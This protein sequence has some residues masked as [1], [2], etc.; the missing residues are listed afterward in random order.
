MRS[1]SAPVRSSPPASRTIPAS[2]STSAAGFADDPGERVDEP[3]PAPD[4]HG[5]P[6]EL[7]RAGDHPRH[8]P[9]RRALGPE[10]C[11]EHPGGEEAVRALR[12]ERAGRPVATRRKGVPGELERTAPTEPPQHP[13]CEAQPCARPELRA[14]DAEAEVDRGHELVELPLPRRAVAGRP[15]VELGDVRLERRVEEHRLT[16]G[17]GGRGR[18]LGV[19]V[20]EAPHVELVRELRIRRGSCEQRMPGA[21]HLVREAGDRVVGLR[22]DRAAE[23]VARLED[24]DAPA[25]S[26]EERRRGERVDPRPD[27]DGVEPGH[28]ATLRGAPE[29]ERGDAGPF[30]RAEPS[31]TRR[32]TTPRATLTAGHPRFESPLI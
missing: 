20:L 30:R 4:R 15:A 8:E 10:T 29:R 17:E 23:P 12:R 3:D 28:A 18:K 27:E 19:D 6:A 32:R 13:S 1:T 16:V 9:R 31:L 21:Q 2:A 26:G 22:P 5:H 11:V 7:D 14:E 24:A 25:L